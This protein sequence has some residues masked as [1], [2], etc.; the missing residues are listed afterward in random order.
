M[1]LARCRLDI[2]KD[3]Q[4][5]AHAQRG[6]VVVAF[7]RI[8]TRFFEQFFEFVLLTFD[9]DGVASIFC[10]SR[11][12]FMRK[13]RCSSGCRNWG[14]DERKMRRA[15]AFVRTSAAMARKTHNRNRLGNEE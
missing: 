4:R 2:R 8:R 7:V 12:G 5:N 11:R 1:A 3:E 14:F 15:T 9:V 13:M 10:G 6:L